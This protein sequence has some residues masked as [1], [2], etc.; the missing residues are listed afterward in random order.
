MQS[1]VY[2][3]GPNGQIIGTPESETGH[4]GPKSRSIF[5][6][7]PKQGKPN[8]SKPTQAKAEQFAPKPSG[9]ARRTSA[10]TASQQP[11]SGQTT[12]IGR[13]PL[14]RIWKIAKFVVISYVV[15]YALLGL[16]FTTSLV[17]VPAMAATP[18]ADTSGT[19]WLL[20]GS[21]SRKGLTLKEQHQLRTGKDEGT[22]RGD[23]IMVLHFGLTGSPTL[24]SLPRDSYVTIPEH[25][26]LDGSEVGKKKNKIN[27]AYAYGG[28]PLLV[29]TVEYNTGLHI[30][31]YMEI[32][33]VGVRDLTNAVK[34]VNICVPENYNDKNSGLKVKKGCQVMSGKTALAYVRMRYADPTGD[35]GRIQRQQQFISAIMHKVATPKT[36]ANPVRMAYLTKAASDSIMVGSSDGLFDI[37]RM[38]LAMR[39]L[40]GGKAKV[41]TV[42]LSNPDATSP[43]GSVVLWDKE[44]SA[45]L[46][47]SIG[48]K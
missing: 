5:L 47:G 39:S 11:R 7:T 10:S 40:A 8:K 35:L 31:H 1:T 36:M 28:A 24:I 13:G 21:D 48:A 41:E 9:L 37:A 19:N 42:P 32:G 18:A 14:K 3:R 34:G 12:S 6:P 30:D 20:V 38:G 46:F 2:R 27:A 15:F 33:F 16:W 45:E 4:L 44:K 22:Q 29:S 17:K 26:A 23:V 25:I 43:V